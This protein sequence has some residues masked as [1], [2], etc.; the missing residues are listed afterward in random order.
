MKLSDLHTGQIAVIAKVGGHGG[1]RK[2][3]VEM[4]FIK[5][6]KIKVVLNAPLRDPIEYELMGYK[7]SLRREEAAMVEVISEEEAEQSL[8]PS[9]AQHLS[10]LTPTEQEQ[11]ELE[12]RMQQM[13]EAQGHTLRVALVGNP[14]C[15]KTSLFNVASGSKEHVGNYAGVTVDAKEGTFQFVRPTTGERY[16]IVL[17]DLPGTY[18]LSAYSAEERYVRSQLIEQTPDVVI[19][20]VDASNLERNL[21]LT[22]QLIDMNLRM[23]VAL[24]MYDEVR[25][26]GDR[27]DYD[28]LGI[29]LG[30]PMVPTVSRAGEGIT[31]L[32]EQ[33]IDVYEYK[34]EVARH[35]HV[36]HGVELEKSIDR[37]KE[38]IQKN[39]QIRHKYSTRYLAIKLLEGDRA[40]NAF[41][42][43]LKNHDELV[44]A[45]YEEQQRIQRELSAGA[46]EALI[47][48]KYGFIQGALKE[49][50]HPSH[51]K[52]HGESRSERIDRI[53]THR[54]LS[55][56][57][58][59]TLLYLIFEATFTLGEYPM[60]WLSWLVD[61]FAAFVTMS[62]PEGILRHLIVDGVIGGVGSVIVFLPNILLLYLFISLLEDTG[63][64][65]RA[66]F[67]TD[68]LMHHIGLHGKS[69]IPMVMG[70]GCN[71][72]SVMATRMI[73]NP[74]SR[75]ITML[76]IPF[77]SC[78]A[79]L[80]I[81]ILLIAAFFPQSGSLVMLALYALG[82][83]V[84]LVSARLFSRYLHVGG[85]LPFVM[86]LPPYRIPTLQSVV[87]HTWEKGQQ[88]L[89]KMAGLI[90][91]FSVVIWALGYFRI[92]GAEAERQPTPNR[93]QSSSLELPRCEGGKDRPAGLTGSAE[94]TSSKAEL[95]PSYLESIGRAV[96]PLFSPM[97]FDW[98]MTVGILSGVGAKELVVST[99][100]VLYADD[101]ADDSADAQ[102]ATRLQTALRARI[103]PPAALAYMV[104]LLLYL[105]CIAT[106]V[107][108]RSESGS[109]RWAL[110]SA[111][112]STI[113]AYALA[114]LTYVGW[115]MVG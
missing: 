66:A 109:W 17:V 93:A 54:W 11:T 67:I 105:P 24:N 9:A 28:Q 34:S 89:R 29:L 42:D 104:F 16:T 56:P 8:R 58:F 6:K 99:L 37:I 46:E 43:T 32:F 114:L 79:R 36:N 50:H 90:L 26:N 87:R 45:R 84:A 39:G 52:K 63:Y 111:A 49:T 103:A 2:R 44:S 88:Y 51:A 25:K 112:Y 47:D 80:P 95:P 97:D 75:L 7:I 92:P 57:I 60:Q 71:V 115:G 35:I 62:M 70:L 91:A 23:V 20:V 98:Q 41:V 48:A 78:S 55:Y 68:K 5:G 110:F 83:A 85:D 107:A 65:A 10:A 13:A 27:L 72:P 76:I 96:A 4:G 64:M 14:N 18:S 19:N 69:L 22:T 15:G 61:Q 33:V 94:L 1:F 108:I 77:M 102:S 101:S 40:Y 73:E 53:V 31:A 100:G 74:K 38:V 30:A 3:I 59:L 21:Y 12:Q 82:I 86:E 106:I 113:I 81:Y